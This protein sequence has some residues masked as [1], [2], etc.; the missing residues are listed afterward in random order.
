[1]LYIRHLNANNMKRK[2]KSERASGVTPACSPSAVE[3][4]HPRGATPGHGRRM[5]PEGRSALA[6]GAPLK[7]VIAAADWSGKRE[8]NS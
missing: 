3:E 5:E 6:A 1:M 4:G 7:A 2:L 8:T